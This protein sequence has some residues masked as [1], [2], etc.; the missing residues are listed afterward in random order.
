MS[1]DQKETSSPPVKQETITRTNK[2]IMLYTLIIVITLSVA[3]ILTSFKL[4]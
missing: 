2:R 1:K 4:L 3:I